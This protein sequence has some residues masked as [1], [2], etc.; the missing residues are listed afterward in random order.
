MPVEIQIAGQRA[1]DLYYQNYKSNSEFFDLA[2]FVA[3]CG[4]VLGGVYEQE[5][6]RARAE[7]RQ[8]KKDAIIPLDA[9][10]LIMQHLKVND[11]YGELF[12]ELEI[13]VMTFPFDNHGVGVQDIY[14]LKPNN[15]IPFERTTATGKYA[16]DYLPVC[17]VIWFYVASATK[18]VLINKTNTKLDTIGVLG[19]PSVD[20]PRLLVPDGVVE[21]VISNAAATIKQAAQGV[22]VKK[23]ADGNPN[24]IIQTE[25]DLSSLKP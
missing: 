8:E 24:K 3:H 23:A 14:P 18:V 11:E 1:M 20:S 25:A 16:L 21:F 10:I 22:I 15:R 7:M 2:D 13:P 19:A 9:G 12:V 5:Y 4:Y 17:G 6:Q